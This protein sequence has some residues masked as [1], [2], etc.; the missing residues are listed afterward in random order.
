MSLFFY[1]E[2]KWERICSFIVKKLNQLACSCEMEPARLANKIICA[3]L[4]SPNFIHSIQKLYN[5]EGDLWV[6]AEWQPDQKIIV[7]R[8]GRPSYDIRR[9]PPIKNDAYLNFRR[10]QRISVSFTNEQ[11]KKLNLLARS[12]K[13]KKA[14]LAALLMHFGLDSSEIILQL[15]ERYNIH[16]HFWVTPCSEDG[17]VRYIRISSR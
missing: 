17:I 14:E 15:Q 8:P 4:D 12:C 7:Y 5:A 6:M 13:L 9:V 16:K 2:E 1:L 3:A 10:D 11:D